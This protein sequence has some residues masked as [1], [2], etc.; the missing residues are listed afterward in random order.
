MPQ[1]LRLKPVP[2]TP[3]PFS[4]TKFGRSGNQFTETQVRPFLSDAAHQQSPVLLRER[5]DAHAMRPTGNRRVA[6]GA[7]NALSRTNSNYFLL[8][9]FTPPG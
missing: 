1:Q 3:F 2:F 8:D 7:T 5:R 6:P 4:S 9:I